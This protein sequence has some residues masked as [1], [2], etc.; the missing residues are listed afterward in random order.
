MDENFVDFRQAIF[1]NETEMKR[2]YCLVV[3]AVIATDIFD[4]ELK[5]SRNNRWTAA[6]A[7]GAANREESE[8]AP[9]D[10]KATIVIEHLIQASDVVHT[11]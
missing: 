8:K 6:F 9:R 10:R 7:E 2:F 5:A 4:P 3:N 1:A 11:M